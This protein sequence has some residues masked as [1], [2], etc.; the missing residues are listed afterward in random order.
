MLDDGGEADLDLGNYE[1]FLDLSLQSVHSL[2]SGKIY[3]RVLKRER[4]GDFLGKTVQMV[5]H[6]TDAIQDWIIDVSHM[7]TDSSGSKPDIC[8]IELGG[9]VGDIESAVYLEALQQ[10]QFRVGC[11]NFLC[12]HLGYVPYMGATGEQKTKPC[13]HSVKVM[14]EAGLKPGILYLV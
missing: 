2:T 13:Q 3:E 1:R 9:T 11:S 6:V 14:R 10:L 7:P 8:L 4:A 5:P 12:V